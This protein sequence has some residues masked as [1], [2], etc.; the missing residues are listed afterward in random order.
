MIMNKQQ[1]EQI[2]K[3]EGYP[4]FMVE[5]TILKIENFCPLVKSAFI[6]WTQTKECENIAIEGYSFFSLMDKYGMTP[7]GAFITL[8]WL[9]REPERAKKKKK[10]GIK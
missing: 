3:D 7:V 4:A 5:K 1:I 10:K 6:K 2:L 9:S 8:D